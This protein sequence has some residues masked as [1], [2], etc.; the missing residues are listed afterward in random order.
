MHKKVILDNNIVLD[1]LLKRESANTLWEAL[2]LYFISHHIDF[3]LAAHQ[4][5]TI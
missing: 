4:I 1:Y 3:C 5:A 2:P